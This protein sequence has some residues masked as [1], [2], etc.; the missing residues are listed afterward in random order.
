VHCRKPGVSSHVTE[1]LQC[2]SENNIYTFI[3][4]AQANSSLASEEE[5]YSMVQINRFLMRY[6][7]FVL[8][9]NML[10]RLSV[11]LT[12]MSVAETVER[13]TVRWLNESGTGKETFV[14]KLETIIKHMPEA[15]Y[16]K[17]ITQ[18]LEKEAAV[19]R[20]E[21]LVCRTWNMCD[22]VECQVNFVLCCC[23]CCS[24]L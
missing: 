23:C 4:K 24:L 6:V 18:R 7:L 2:D 17:H 1:I 19:L 5:F 16:I 8:Y 14:P 22:I 15:I 12:T 9:L 3:H 10:L 11:C 20:F 21:P 13:R